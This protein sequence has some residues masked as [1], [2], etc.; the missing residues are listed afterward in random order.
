MSK[1]EFK[2]TLSVQENDLVSSIMETNGELNTSIFIEK[3]IEVINANFTKEQLLMEFDSYVKPKVRRMT[4]LTDEQL[5]FIDDMSQ[6]SGLNKS[7]VII[8][9]A[10]IIDR[11]FSGGLEK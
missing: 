1:H 4:R 11:Y 9:I 5:V 8:E 6:S 3:V 7:R 10:K 2:M